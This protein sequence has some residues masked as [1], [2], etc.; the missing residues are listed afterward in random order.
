MHFIL[1]AKLASELKTTLSGS[2]FHTFTTRSLKKDDLTR[3]DIQISYY[4]YYYYWTVH[5]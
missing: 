4:Y 3:T 1:R 5:N 2:L